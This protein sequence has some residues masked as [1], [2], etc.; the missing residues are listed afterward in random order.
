MTTATTT[1]DNLSSRHEAG[2][3]RTRNNT[4]NNIALIT[5]YCVALWHCT[6]SVHGDIMT[7][8]SL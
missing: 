6:L 4:C 3:R 7:D 5:P 8:G 1:N 2:T